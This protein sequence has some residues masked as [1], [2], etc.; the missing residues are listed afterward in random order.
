MHLPREGDPATEVA[1]YGQ[2]SVMARNHKSYVRNSSKLSGVPLFF[3]KICLFAGMEVLSENL[4]SRVTAMRPIDAAR[5]G[6][7]FGL[8][9]IGAARFRGLM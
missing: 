3:A 1:T 9:L 2:P 5:A 8:I 6:K 7:V 4:Q